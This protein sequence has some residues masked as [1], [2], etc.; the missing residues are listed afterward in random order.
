MPEIIPAIDEIY[1]LQNVNKLH[2]CI[3]FHINRVMHEIANKY[4]CRYYEWVE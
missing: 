1:H 3:K 2:N 4:L